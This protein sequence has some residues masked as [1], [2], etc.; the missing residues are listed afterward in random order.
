MQVELTQHSGLRHDGQLIEFDLWQ[1]HA[2]GLD[3]NRVLVAYLFHDPDTG[4]KVVPPLPLYDPPEID[5]SMGLDDE[6]DD[7]EG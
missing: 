2:T 4:R 7:I 3:G 1:V 6:D 5:N